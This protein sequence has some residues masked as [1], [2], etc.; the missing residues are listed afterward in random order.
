MTNHKSEPTDASHRVFLADAS[1]K[2]LQQRKSSLCAFQ[3]LETSLGSLSMLLSSR[4]SKQLDTDNEEL[5]KQLQLNTYYFQ[6]Y[7]VK[8]KKHR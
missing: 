1:G 2:T 4:S 8:V 5:L 6:T 3:M 7:L